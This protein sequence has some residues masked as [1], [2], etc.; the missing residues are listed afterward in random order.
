MSL[1]YYYTIKVC[2]YALPNKNMSISNWWI[3]QD[4]ISILMYESN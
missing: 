3:T 2:I 1:K 4:L